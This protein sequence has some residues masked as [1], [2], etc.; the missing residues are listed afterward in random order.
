MLFIFSAMIRHFFHKRCS[1]Y[2]IGISYN[3]NVSNL[4]LQAGLVT[5]R[6]SFKIHSLSKIMILHLKRFSYGNHGSAK[7]YKPL[8][9]PLQLV[10]S[11]DLLT[12]PS[13]EV[14]ICQIC[15]YK[16]LLRYLLLYFYWFDG[17]HVQACF[18]LS[19][20]LLSLP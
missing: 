5:A 17:L 12:S 9:F 11:R 2:L 6:K 16:C 15:F 20:Y 4:I 13:S 19:L 8:H 3:Y 1:Y 18:V 10:L 7:V 14:I